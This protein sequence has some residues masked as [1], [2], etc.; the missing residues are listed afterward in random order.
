MP[1]FY[2]RLLLNAA[3]NA[4]IKE[5]Q[6]RFGNN[7]DFPKDEIGLKQLFDQLDKLVPKEVQTTGTGKQIR[8]GANGIS[9][10]RK[11]G[12]A[13]VHGGRHFT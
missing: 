5:A 10:C 8:T 7:P 6:T 3:S 9:E 4:V 1:L 11:A 13:R 2:A 12:F